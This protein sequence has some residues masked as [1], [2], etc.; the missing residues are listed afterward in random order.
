MREAMPPLDEKKTIADLALPDTLRKLF[1]GLGFYDF[2]GIYSVGATC[3]EYFWRYLGNE[4]L[5]L[6]I[7]HFKK[8]GLWSAKKY[9]ITNQCVMEDKWKPLFIARGLFHDEEFSLLRQMD[10]VSWS[11]YDS[12]IT[13]YHDVTPGFLA[14]CKIHFTNASK[15][16]H[17]QKLLNDLCGTSFVDMFSS[18]WDSKSRNIFILRDLENKT[19]NE[20]STIAELIRERVRQI[21]RKMEDGI[22]V[23]LPFI[24]PLDQCAA[25]YLYMEG[26]FDLF[27]GVMQQG[28][29]F[30][31]IINDLG[32]AAE[33]QRLILL[34]CKL[35]FNATIEN[36]NI[37]FPKNGC[38]VCKRLCDK[39]VNAFTSET[40]LSF[41][42]QC[43]IAQSECKECLLGKRCIENMGTFL[44]EFYKNNLSKKVFFNPQDKTLFSGKEYLMHR[45]TRREIIQNIL[46]PNK[47]LSFMEIYNEL[48]KYR[49]DLGERQV[50]GY[51]Q[52]SDVVLVDRGVYMLAS[53][54][55]SIPIDLLSAC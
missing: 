51:I 9:Q 47:K 27:R 42:S 23:S 18:S 55:P 48:L 41:E 16:K 25:L 15:I 54:L 7:Q 34:F 3:I 5:Q 20:V 40:S 13:A 19:L 50:Y 31:H 21:T 29:L 46:S 24:L 53:A 39:F 32:F 33:D 49:S 1:H 52:S 38:L 30:D 36:G 10:I 8:C 44:P 28:D 12:Y 22:V 17:F 45:G 26:L 37:R 35:N 4:N 11:D 2:D 14:I 6:L 43:Q